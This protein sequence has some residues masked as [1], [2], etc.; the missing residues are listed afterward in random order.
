DEATLKYGQAHQPW[1]DDLDT[2]LTVMYNDD[3]TLRDIANHF[4][5]TKGAI[6]SRIKKLGLNG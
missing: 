3:I 5:R 4:G 1:T 6:S 2:E